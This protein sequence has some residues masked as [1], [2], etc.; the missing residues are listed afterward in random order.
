[1]SSISDI[2]PA[3]KMVP[4][5]PSDTQDVPGIPR[6]IWVGTAG[7]VSCIGANDSAASTPVVLVG[8]SGLLPVRVRRILVTGTTASNIVALF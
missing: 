7:N 6:A 8:V 2:V 5:T 1:M 4:V 3:T